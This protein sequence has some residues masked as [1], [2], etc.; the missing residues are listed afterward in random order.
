MIAHVPSGAV[1]PSLTTNRLLHSPK[2]FAATIVTGIFCLTLLW[3]V[4][5]FWNP[6][7]FFGLWTSAILTAR[8][9]AGDHPLPVRRH[10]TLSALS[11]PLWWWFELLNQSVRNWDYANAGHYNYI[12]YAIFATIAFSTVIP[13][14]DAAW[15]L[16]LRIANAPRTPVPNADRK[17][18]YA[19][20][21]GVGLAAQ[22]MVFLEPGVYYSL[23]WLGPF[24]ILDGASGMIGAGSLLGELQARRW[25]LPLTLALAGIG[26]GLCWEFWNYWAVPKWTYSVPYFDFF[27]VFE[28]PLLGYLG[29]VP[30]IWSVYQALRL[31]H[32]R[33]PRWLPQP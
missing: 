13:A 12:E 10:L 24:F 33:W 14:L 17:R 20:L 32:H 2:W 7:L 23:V 6:L 1:A 16:A 4:R 11:I 15:R 26:C 31:L 28:M 18:W 19:L 30:F 3:T 5:T 27:K 25:R 9:L 22:A 29:Y 8:N 21:V